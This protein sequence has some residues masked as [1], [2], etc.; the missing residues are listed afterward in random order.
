MTLARQALQAK[1][2]PI[3][4][5]ARLAGYQSVSAFSTAYRRRTGFPPS[6]HWGREASAQPEDAQGTVLRATL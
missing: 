2:R 3:A 6:A 1:D 4:E 5:I